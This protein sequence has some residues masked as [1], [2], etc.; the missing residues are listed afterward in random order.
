M[1]ADIT[2]P[3][4]FLF[5]ESQSCFVVSVKESNS[6]EFC[7]ITGAVK[8]GQLTSARRFVFKKYFDLDAKLLE[9]IYRSAL[10]CMLTEG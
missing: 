5:A 2:N 3:T 1:D 4:A 9:E 8:I 6:D 7:R 10:E